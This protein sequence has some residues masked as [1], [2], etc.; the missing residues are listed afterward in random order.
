MAMCDHGGQNVFAVE[1]DA[2][3]VVRNECKP[4]AP[5]RA[6]AHTHAKNFTRRFGWTQITRREGG[7]GAALGEQGVFQLARA[8][9]DGLEMRAGG[10]PLPCGARGS[11]SPLNN[12]ALHKTYPTCHQHWL[13]E[14]RPSHVPPALARALVEARM[15][16]PHSRIGT[17]TQTNWTS[18]TY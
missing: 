17:P 15:G 12:G 8:A 18:T 16:P 11:T 13:R 2:P 9:I 10:P 5:P 6:R 7:R 4:V 14:G 1:P 3:D